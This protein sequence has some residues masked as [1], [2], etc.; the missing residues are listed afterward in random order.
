MVLQLPALY[1][2]ISRHEQSDTT[3]QVSYSR[4]SGVVG[5]VG[6]GSQWF[7][8]YQLSIWKY[9]DMNKMTDLTGR[10]QSGIWGCGGGG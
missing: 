8:S 7:S 6:K 2:E 4:G 9:P 1:M 5:V 10:L 3:S